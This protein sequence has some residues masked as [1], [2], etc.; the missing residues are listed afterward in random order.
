VKHGALKRKSLEAVKG[1]EA[2]R[3]DTCGPSWHRR[4][5]D[6]NEEEDEDALEQVAD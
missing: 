1:G 5:E 2:L 3:R 4:I 6:E